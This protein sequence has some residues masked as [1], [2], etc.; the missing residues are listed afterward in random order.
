MLAVQFFDTI[1]E[2]IFRKEFDEKFGQRDKGR[3]YK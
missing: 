2:K 3:K 1:L